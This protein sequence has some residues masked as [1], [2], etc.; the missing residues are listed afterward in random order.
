MSDPQTLDLTEPVEQN[1]SE[2]IEDVFLIPPL[3]KKHQKN[4]KL[5]NQ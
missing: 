4:Q 3:L 5:Q 2:V 1:V